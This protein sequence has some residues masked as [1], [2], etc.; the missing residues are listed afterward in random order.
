MQKVS[1]KFL[2]YWSKYNQMERAACQRLGPDKCQVITNEDLGRNP[3]VTLES[4]YGWMGE[5]FDANGLHKICISVF[6]QFHF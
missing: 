6:H 1:Q 3:L 5:E 4:I 2:S